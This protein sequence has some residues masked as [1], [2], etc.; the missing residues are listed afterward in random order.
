MVDLK[1]LR[2]F[3]AYMNREAVDSSGH[4][5]RNLEIIHAQHT[6]GNSRSRTYASIL[7]PVEFPVPRSSVKEHPV[8]KKQ[9]MAIV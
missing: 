9:I 8:L 4:E 5:R 2:T 6:R 3:L 7:A 1:T